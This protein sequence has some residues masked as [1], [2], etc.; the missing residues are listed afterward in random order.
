MNVRILP[1]A[2]N[3]LVAGREFYNLQGEGLG[4]Y[5]FDSLF[6]DIDSLRLYGGIHRK[7]FGHHRLLSDRFPF[8]IYYKVEAD[9]TA[10]VYRVLDCRQNPQK[11]R[12]A[13]R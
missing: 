13:L 12:R 7:V 1:S 4:S 2:F 8:A 9:D 6:A 5:F 3:D 10:V 11:T